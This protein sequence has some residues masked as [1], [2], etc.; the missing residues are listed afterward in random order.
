MIKLKIFIIDS[1]DLYL[2]VY[3]Y[4]NFIYTGLNLP[5][6]QLIL[7]YQSLSFVYLV[8]CKKKLLFKLFGLL[9]L[10]LLSLG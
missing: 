6:I 10:L 1:Y 9:I 4:I 2:Y 3:T 5:L 7:I 8:I